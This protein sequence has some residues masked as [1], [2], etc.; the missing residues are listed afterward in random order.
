MTQLPLLPIPRT[1]RDISRGRHNPNSK[2][3]SERVDRVTM[4][5]LV[6]RCLAEKPKTRK[7][8]A[9]ELRIPI[10]KI[11]G[12][13]TELRDDLKL[14]RETGVSRDGSGEVAAR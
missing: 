11:S 7:E 3:A 13:F 14:I 4:R 10:H 6:L 2:A 9:D 5:D 8:I 12:R 1:E